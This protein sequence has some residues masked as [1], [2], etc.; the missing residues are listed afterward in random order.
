MNALKEVERGNVGR[1][2][3]ANFQPLRDVPAHLVARH[4]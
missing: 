3:I 1:G 4:A 2:S